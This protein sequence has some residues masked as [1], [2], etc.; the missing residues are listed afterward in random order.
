MNEFRPP[1]HVSYIGLLAVIIGIVA[2]I[3]RRLHGNDTLAAILGFLAIILGLIVVLLL[4][5]QQGG[6]QR[7]S[8]LSE[9][10]RKNI[11]RSKRNSQL[12]VIF[13]VFSFVWLG[14]GMALF[15]ASESSTLLFYT[16]L[17][18]FLFGCAFLFWGFA[19]RWAIK[20]GIIRRRH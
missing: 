19:I 12:G 11:A 15:G 1:R 13:L 20:L 4:S 10:V 9:Y 7:T 2:I 17:A 5:E 14:A 16:W 6:I 3:Y 18:I 8:L